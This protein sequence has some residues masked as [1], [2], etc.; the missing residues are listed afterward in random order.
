MVKMEKPDPGRGPDR[1]LAARSS[2]GSLHHDAEQVSGCG[3]T[4]RTKPAG[5]NQNFKIR[6]ISTNYLVRHF[7]AKARRGALAGGLVLLAWNECPHSSTGGSSRS[8]RP[9]P[10]LL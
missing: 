7:N 10:W 5:V 1:A 6:F 9:F 3:S 8:G 2:S 4:G